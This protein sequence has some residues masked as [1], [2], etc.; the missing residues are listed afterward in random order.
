[1]DSFGEFLKRTLMVFVFWFLIGGVLAFT[2]NMLVSRVYTRR[3]NGDDV[4]EDELFLRQLDDYQM[5]AFALCLG[6]TAVTGRILLEFIASNFGR[7][8]AAV[9]SGQ[10]IVLKSELEHTAES[11][12]EQDEDARQQQTAP[13]PMAHPVAPP[14]MQPAMQQPVVQPV[15]GPVM[16]SAMQSAMQPA[17]Q[18][19]QAPPPPA[20]FAR[21]PY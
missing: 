7:D 1:M 18:Q 14:A 16:Q 12:L 8:T 2:Y 20:A 9:M 10:A 3:E 6:A 13:Q 11:I 5:F 15:A 17:V 21:P 4:D 19:I